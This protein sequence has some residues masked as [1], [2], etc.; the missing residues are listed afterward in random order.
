M[1]GVSR[2]S[3]NLLRKQKLVSAR[4]RIAEECQRACVREICITDE[5][6][7]YVGGKAPSL[8]II[9]GQ[10]F[11]D[12][13]PVLLILPVGLEIVFALRSQNR[14]ILFPGFWSKL[15]VQERYK[16]SPFLRLL[17]HSLQ[18]IAWRPLPCNYYV[19]Q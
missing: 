8:W 1:T 12:A 13:E 17:S 11:D 6:S 18:G 9:G 4:V 3:L 16:V 10:E 2:Q 15:A 5:V 19:I 7:D 14:Q